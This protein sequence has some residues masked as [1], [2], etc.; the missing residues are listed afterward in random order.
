MHDN[1]KFITR[2]WT[3]NIEPTKTIAVYNLGQRNTGGNNHVQAVRQCDTVGR[4][5]DK[6]DLEISE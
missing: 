5:Q 2:T 4:H 6:E 1:R 3:E